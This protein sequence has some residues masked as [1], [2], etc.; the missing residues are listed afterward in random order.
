[1]EKNRILYIDRL[2]GINIFL[3]VMGHVFAFN[4]IDSKESALFAWGSTFRMPLFMFLCGY[5]AC[6]LIT[7]NIFKD[8]SKFIIKKSRTLL[9]PFFAWSLIADN[10]FFTNKTEFNI[11][12][13]FL[14]LINGGGLWFLWSL[15]FATLLYSFWLFLSDKFNQSD[16]FVLDCLICFCLLL[17]LVLIAYLNITPMAKPFIFFFVF[18]FM[19]V[20]VAK[21]DFLSKTMMNKN[22]FA[23]ALVLFIVIVGRYETDGSYIN[24]AIKWVTAVVAICSFYY[25]IR[26]IS[27]NPMVDKF[28]RYCGVNSLIIYVT[29]FH[30][31]YIFST[32]FISS[33][34]NKI[35]LILT[36]FI[37]SI[38]VVTMCLAIFSILKMSN[39]FGFLLYGRKF[40]LK[41]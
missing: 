23:I 13:T 31:V 12:E 11:L 16:S 34:M 36:V 35:P 33:E 14:A 30:L 6:K 26:N 15:F 24:I 8:Y 37:I 9:V 3:V 18:Y 38:V 5:I 25:I 22:I 32:P 20:F 28:V 19:G 39:I 21:F 27:W 41:D 4:V 2:R 29:H 7:P 1:M 10:F 40:K 17:G